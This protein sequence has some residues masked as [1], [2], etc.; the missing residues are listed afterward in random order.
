[1]FSPPAF[2]VIM[3]LLTVEGFANFVVLLNRVAENGLRVGG[4][5]WI[6]AKKYFLLALA[7]LIFNFLVAQSSR[8]QIIPGTDTL[9]VSR[10]AK[11]NEETAQ[12][13]KAKKESAVTINVK[14]VVQVNGKFDTTKGS[15][16]NKVTFSIVRGTLTVEPKFIDSGNNQNKSQVEIAIP[17]EDWP[18]DC[19][20]KKINLNLTLWVPPVTDE[21][22]FDQIGQ[23]IIAGQNS[24]G[25]NIVISNDA[26]FLNT[27]Y[28]PNK[29][30]WVEV[31]SNFDLLDGIQANNPFFGV[32]FHKRDIRPICT[33]GK[34]RPN[35]AQKNFGIFAGV[36]GSRT[37][38]VNQT[39]DLFIRSYFNNNSFIPGKPDSLKVF[40]DAG[41]YATK[42][43]V[44]NIGLFFSPQVRLTEGSANADGL[45][46]SLSFWME[47]QWQ[48]IT[49]ENDFS[50]LVRIDSSI[51]GI[52]QIE[53]LSVK[54]LGFTNSQKTESDIRSHYFGFGLP[55]YFR[56]KDVHLF[57]HPIIGISNQPTAAYLRA[58]Q[59]FKPDGLNIKRKWSPFYAIQFRL[60]EEKYGI[61][62]TGEVRGLLSKNNSPFVSIALSKKFDLNKFI[63]F[64]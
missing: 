47:L 58:Q 37:I 35:N 32:F 63:E 40:K 38:T 12:N 44:K 54:G 34:V 28:N 22:S 21:V 24:T 7:S 5:I 52:N 61:A 15:V 16:N 14:V 33:K 8:F 55:I 10:E 57:V 45:H 46:I 41:K 23:I 56:E 1:V 17:E 50:Q 49:Q 20:P 48:Q 11:N 25:H 19:A 6:M 31:G 62:F 29:P 42:T 51:R 53:S 30:F 18:T 3:P 64:K 39:E 13:D 27:K 60:N 26:E 2:T 59:Q 43:S 9:A 36:F 4:K